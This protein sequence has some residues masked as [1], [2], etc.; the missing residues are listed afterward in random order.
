M[1]TK[2]KQLLSLI[3]VIIIFVSDS[4]C[5]KKETN[6]WP[7]ELGGTFVFLTRS[8][9]DN[10]SRVYIMNSTG[11]TKV[12]DQPDIGAGK[13]SP[14]GTKILYDCGDW[15]YLMN[16]WG[17]DKREFE[18]SAPVFSPDGRKIAFLHEIYGTDG[19]LGDSLCFMNADGSGLVRYIFL[20]YG[21]YPYL[22]EW[23]PD[24]ANIG[25]STMKE[26]PDHSNIVA[27]S[28]GYI[29]EG[30]FHLLAKGSF[31]VWTH[32]GSQLLFHNANAL[33]SLTLSDRSIVK[34]ADIHDSIDFHWAPD[35]SRICYFRY[36]DL[37]VMKMDGS[38]PVKVAS[39]FSDSPSCWS[40]DGSRIAYISGDLSVTVINADGSNAITFTIGSPFLA[41]TDY[42]AFLDWY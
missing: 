12:A 11:I 42:L 7:G 27:D 38:A 8:H 17:P 37:Y 39:N 22:G 2:G 32:D 28:A 33:W 21:R 25:L 16:G 13:W 10:V 40:R 26:L 1:K 20:P 15:F 14:D 36:N 24:G 41:A 9:H 30:G 34:L 29:N 3:L 35:K 23:S 18:G 4:G 19:T 31:S 6:Y 5:K